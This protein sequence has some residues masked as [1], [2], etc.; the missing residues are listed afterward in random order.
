LAIHDQPL[1]PDH[2][3]F[4]SEGLNTAS[5]EI[6]PYL[7]PASYEEQV[8]PY[9]ADYYQLPQGTAS[10]SFSGAPDVSVL[11]TEPVNG[12]R[13]WFAQRANYSN[14]RLTYSFDLSDLDQATLNYDVYADIERGYDF[15]YVSVSIDDGHTWI[16]L[17]AEQM[18]GLLSEDNP[19]GSALADRFYT[20]R[21]QQWSSETIDLTPY[22]GQE[23]LLR[24][25]Y[26]TDPILTYGGFALDNVSIEELGF[27]DGAEDSDHGAF[28]EGFIP[29]T[30]SIPQTWHLQH[31][32]FED[33]EPQIQYFP[34]DSTGEM[35]LTFEKPIA[36]ASLLIVAAQAPTTLEKSG[37]RLTL[38]N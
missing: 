10:I 35:L 6:V 8:S 24:F 11:G 14:P 13:Y 18:Q 32:T 3:R 4:Q 30:A 31:I 34:V 2:V 20:G 37:Y 36:E 33:G 26:V 17:V 27:V 22:V 23:I 38:E 7:L 5:T 21:N 25:E 29:V 9:A 19:S 16:P 15:A 28:A 1:A 12:E